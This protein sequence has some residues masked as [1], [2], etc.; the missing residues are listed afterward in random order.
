MSTDTKAKCIYGI[1]TRVTY[2]VDLRQLLDGQ[3]TRIATVDAHPTGAI[4]CENLGRKCTVVDRG[5][6]IYEL[7]AM[8]C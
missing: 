8:E 7:V 3:W 1:I 5:N 6:G 4:G 2:T